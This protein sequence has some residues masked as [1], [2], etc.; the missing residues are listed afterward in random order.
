MFIPKLG[1][2]TINQ[3]ELLTF[4]QEL[5][6]FTQV[7]CMN[8]ASSLVNYSYTEMRDIYIRL[9]KLLEEAWVLVPIPLICRWMSDLVSRSSS[10]FTLKKFEG[11]I[12]LLIYIPC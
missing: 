11:V 8:R 10:L 12:I 9:I 1:N 7:N 6:A 5:I 2:Y 4:I 3:T